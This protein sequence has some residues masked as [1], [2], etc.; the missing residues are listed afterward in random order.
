MWY[1]YQNVYIYK[2]LVNK[3]LIKPYNK[4]IQTSINNKLHYNYN[5]MV[6]MYMACKTKK[7]EFI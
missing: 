1:V 3:Q 7:M 5:W 6:N 2:L 4:Y